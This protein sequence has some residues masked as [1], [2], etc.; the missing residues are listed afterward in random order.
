MHYHVRVLAGRVDRGA[1]S[2]VYH[3]ATL[4]RWI[5]TALYVHLQ[6]RALNRAD[7][8]LRFTEMSC[9]ALLRRYGRSV[10]PRFFVNPQATELPPPPGARPH[11]D[12]VRLLWVGQL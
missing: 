7:R 2:H 5:S 11:A 9:D 3:L 1:G 10:R 6:R 12:V 4:M 8:T